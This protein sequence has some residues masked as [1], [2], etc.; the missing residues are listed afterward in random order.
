MVLSGSTL[1]AGQADSLRGPVIALR[2]EL[3]AKGVVVAD[4][5]G[6]RFTQDHLF[7]S[8]SLAASLVAGTTV[9]AWM[10]GAIPRA[11]PSKSPVTASARRDL[12]GKGARWVYTVYIY[13]QA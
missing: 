6:Y 12:A 10:P 5:E 3:L 8:P 11:S 4:G 7:N 9:V 2:D 1:N 13:R